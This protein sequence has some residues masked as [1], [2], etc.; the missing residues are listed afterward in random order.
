VRYY[1]VHVHGYYLQNTQ[2]FSLVVTSGFELRQETC[3]TTPLPACIECN[4][5]TCAASRTCACPSTQA[6]VDCST[7]LVSLT[8]CEP[9]VVRVGP[10]NTAYFDY[11][12]TPG[13][14]TDTIIYVGRRS[15]NTYAKVYVSTTNPV[16]T[17]ADNDFKLTTNSEVLRISGSNMPGKKCFIAVEST[18]NMVVTII[19]FQNVPGLTKLTIGQQTTGCTIPPTANNLNH[20]MYLDMS[21]VKSYFQSGSRRIEA[22]GREAMRV[23][24][25][26]AGHKPVA[27]AKFS[28][29]SSLPTTSDFDPYLVAN[30]ENDLYIYQIFTLPNWITSN[31]VVFGLYS[32]GAGPFT[33]QVDLLDFCSGNKVITQ[34]PTT[35]SPLGI[36]DHRGEGFYAPGTSCTWALEPSDSTIAGMKL[37]FNRF[38]LGV[39]DTLKIYN[40]PLSDAPTLLYTLE[41]SF[42]QK[43]IIINSKKASL[44][45]SAD[46]YYQAMGFDISY[47]VV[48]TACPN[49]CSGHGTCSNGVCNCDSGYYTQDCSTLGCPTPTCSGNGRC[50]FEVI[51]P[52][53]ECGTGYWGD[54]CDYQCPGGASS[55]C[56]N[57]GKCEL[58]GTCTCLSP[59]Y[60][61]ACQYQPCARS[62]GPHGRCNTA[63][64]KC[65]CDYG[66][67]GPGPNNDCELECPGGGNNPCS[68]NGTCVNGICNCFS[69]YKGAACDQKDCAQICVHGTC[70]KLHSYCVCERGWWGDRCNTQ[71]PGGIA[72]VCSGHG[73]CS[74]SNGA[75]TC[76]DEWA[77][78][79][80]DTRPHVVFMKDGPFSVVI[81]PSDEVTYKIFIKDVPDDESKS[82]SAFGKPNR[83]PNALDVPEYLHNYALKVS[84]DNT[85]NP[86]VNLYTAYKSMPSVN[87]HD[88]TVGRLTSSQNEYDLKV[89]PQGYQYMYVNF[90]NGRSSGAQLTA[91][92]TV[93]RLN[94]EPQGQ[95]DLEAHVSAPRRGISLEG[96]LSIIIALLA[97]LFILFLLLA[98]ILLLLCC[99]GCPKRKVSKHTE[100]D[101]VKE[102]ELKETKKEIAVESPPPYQ[103]QSVYIPDDDSISSTI[104]RVES[105]AR[106]E[107]PLEVQPVTTTIKTTITTVLVPQ[108]DGG[109]KEEKIV[110][111]DGAPQS[112]IAH[113]QALTQSNNQGPFVSAS[114]YRGTNIDTA[115]RVTPTNNSSTSFRNIAQSSL[116]SAQTTS[117]NVNRVGRD[118]GR[119]GTMVSKDLPSLSSGNQASPT[120]SGRYRLDDTSSDSSS[121]EE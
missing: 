48:S 53:C 51:P 38:S 77:G 85:V 24:I 118:G 34:N 112:D 91:E 92:L 20:F 12:R 75:C 8:D 2:D 59:F 105:K 97:L 57:R 36:L 108:D 29:D 86:R 26:G 56:S 9:S 114:D 109:F 41:D 100:T 101:K 19:I 76:V 23:S 42:N 4:T 54:N 49:A 90:Q 102:V 98:L 46:G 96:I 18:V 47:S 110:T 39:G 78:S 107:N 15:E 70:D 27:L 74:S 69:P 89:I 60:G 45:F 82:L 50:K 106:I 1:A 95:P 68:G 66:Y 115:R 80:C 43:E 28:N 22:A 3:S 14:S 121:D 73:T 64:G 58:N 7:S 13:T 65:I 63:T 87:N 21:D 52:Y 32:N 111:V 6:G 72:S 25:T 88:E 37:K 35:S 83:N 119:M 71:C 116:A 10:G 61:S 55:P 84:S 67:Y 120:D 99:I 30:T 81:P 31:R 5:G 103:P 33:L 11:Q 79:Q 44:V 104:Q 62:C 117:N 17:S 93:D 40:G 16:P 94:Y 113:L